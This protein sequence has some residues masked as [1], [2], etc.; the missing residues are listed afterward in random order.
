MRQGSGP[1][2]LP[3][4]FPLDDEVAGWEE[5]AT[6]Y[7]GC[8]MHVEWG[9]PA[10][11]TRVDRPLPPPLPFLSLV[12]WDMWCVPWRMRKPTLFSFHHHLPF[13]HHHHHLLRLVPPPRRLWQ[14]HWCDAI[15]AVED[16]VVGEEEEE[17]V[18]VGRPPC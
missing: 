12:P 6:P 16:E 8:R 18:D 11:E 4:L 1:A 15:A 9:R 13:H 10:L 7:E 5:E 2:R 17:E 14:G 3:L